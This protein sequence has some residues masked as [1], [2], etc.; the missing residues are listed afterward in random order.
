M[1]QKKLTVL[2]AGESGVGA[3]LLARAK[4]WEV[5]VSDKGTI[6]DQHKKTLMANDIP[7]EEGRHEWATILDSTEVVKSPGI[8]ETTDLVVALREKGIPVIS[9]IEWAA[10][11]TEAR[12]IG[13]TGTN[14]KTTTTRLT[15]HLLK[16]GGL[17][18]AMAG[19]VGVSFARLVCEADPPD[20]YVLELS[21]FQLD[22]IQDFRADIS[23]LLNITPDHL[24]RYDYQMDNYID[25]KFRITRNQGKQDWF[26]YNGE[27]ANVA[28]GFARHRI[29]AKASPIS[30]PPQAGI[31][32]VDDWQ[33]DLESTQLKG[34]HNAFNANCAVRIARKLGVSPDRIQEGLDSFQNAPHRMEL[35]GTHEEVDY[36]ND[37]KATNVEAALFALQAMQ[38]P[39]IWIAGGTDKGNDYGPLLDLVNDKVRALICMGL[40]NE[41][42]KKAF[43]G[44]VEQMVEVAS[45]SEAVE[46]AR[47]WAKPG[48]VVLLSPACASFDLFNNYE[49]RGDQFRKAVQR[50][51]N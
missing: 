36:I 41:K 4:G 45:A 34:P 38:K 15:Y 32:V 18:V 20:W 46:Q 2:G 35:V 50:L 31:L 24:D 27:D 44:K 5:W 33:Y 11:F 26:L 28:K 43:R 22:G 40:D 8:P 3:A 9:E 16:E 29:E 37:S 10:R 25:S 42:L 48:E 30:Y 14:G 19:N 49:D 39:V 6:A 21:S 51:K 17:K 7:Y 47:K 13:I 23:V 12:L 1:K